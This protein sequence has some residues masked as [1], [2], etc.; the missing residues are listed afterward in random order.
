MPSLRNRGR[1]IRTPARVQRLGP[2]KTRN[3]SRHEGKRRGLG[4][5]HAFLPQ[6]NRRGDFRVSSRSLCC[7]MD[8]Q[9]LPKTRRRKWRRRTT[10]RYHPKIAR[11]PV[12]HGMRNKFDEKGEEKKENTPTQIDRSRRT[13]QIG[14]GES[15]GTWRKRGEGGIRNS[16]VEDGR[17]RRTTRVV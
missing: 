6:T 2:N 15:T 10:E 7:C 11:L 14:R 9:R 12:A 4:T 5:R 17:E 8:D 13:L 3:R 1:Y 16:G